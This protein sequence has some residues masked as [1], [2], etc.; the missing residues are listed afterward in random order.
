MKRAAPKPRNPVARVVG[1]IRPKLVPD[2]RRKLKE[3]VEHKLSL[4]ETAR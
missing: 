2:K 3:R 4:R 1:A